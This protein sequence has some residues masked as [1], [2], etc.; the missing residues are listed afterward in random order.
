M[1][2]Y[3]FVLLHVTVAKK[4]DT[5]SISYWWDEVLFNV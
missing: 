2:V 3:V 5:T 4:R 1:P